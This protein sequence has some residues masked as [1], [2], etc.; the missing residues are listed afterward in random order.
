VP[1]LALERDAGN[2]VPVLF[3]IIDDKNIPTR[4]HKP[5]LMLGR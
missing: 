1:E 2:R 5:S 3:I 4:A